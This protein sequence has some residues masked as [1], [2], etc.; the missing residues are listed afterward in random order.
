MHNYVEVLRHRTFTNILYIIYLQPL[1][2][3]RAFYYRDQPGGVYILAENCSWLY[4]IKESC[5]WTN[6]VI[7]AL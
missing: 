5:F 2:Q 3:L 1:M 4:L 6:N 7:V